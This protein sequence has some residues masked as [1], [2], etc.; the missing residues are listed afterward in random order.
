[1]VG[2]ILPRE[3]GR[4]H[5]NCLIGQKRREIPAS[6]VMPESGIFNS[7]NYVAVM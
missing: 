6:S 7:C 2:M 3:G 4:V 5:V 1:M